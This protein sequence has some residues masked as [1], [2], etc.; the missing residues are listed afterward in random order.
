MPVSDELMVQIKADITQF[1]QQI[2]DVNQQL[3][4][5]ANGA[6]K[7][8]TEFARSFMSAATALRNFRSAMVA[9]GNTAQKLQG[10]GNRKMFSG[11]FDDARNK[12]MAFDA[13][14][15]RVKRDLSSIGS[16]AD[17]AGAKIT[18]AFGAATV[19]ARGFK[20]AMSANHVALSRFKG[21]ASQKL[22]P[23]NEFKDSVKTLLTFHNELKRVG[24]AINKVDG[25]GSKELS[26]GFNS[27]LG[28]ARDLT[29]AVNT[30]SGAFSGI[31][32]A[33][34]ALRDVGESMIDLAGVG[35]KFQDSKKIFEAMGQ[36]LVDFRNATKG[37][38]SDQQ[39][40]KGFGLASSMGLTANEFK[41]FANIAAAAAKKMGVEQ[42]YAF[43][44]IVVGASRSSKKI[45]DNIGIIVDFGYAHEEF[46]KKHG[47][48]VQQLTDEEKKQSELNQVL[49]QGRKIMDDVKAVGADSSEVYDRY[50]ASIENLKTT[51]GSV[52]IPILEH[53]AD[54]A[55]TLRFALEEIFNLDTRSLTT[56]AADKIGTQKSLAQAFK[57]S[58]EAGYITQE[59]A[60]IMMTMGL[61]NDD[62]REMNAAIANNDGA[63]MARLGKKNV[64]G[65][66]QE[67]LKDAVDKKDE[68]KIKSLQEQL[69]LYRALLQVG[70]A[71]DFTQQQNFLAQAEKLMDDAKKT[72]L[73]ETKRQKI[74]G[75]A[76]KGGVDYE[77]DN[78]NAAKTQEK[79]RNQLL[80]DR[81]ELE[82]KISEQLAK[83]A[84]DTAISAAAF[85]GAVE[86]PFQ[87]LLSKLR[88]LDEL[89]AKNQQL[90]GTGAANNLAGISQMTAYAV[91][92]MGN[93]V[94]ETII[95]QENLND[96]MGIAQEFFGKLVSAD[97]S[98]ITDPQALEAIQ[99]SIQ[100]IDAAF[101]AAESKI[102][103]KKVEKRGEI[104]EKIGDEAAR[105]YSALQI[106]AS[107]GSAVEQPFQNLRDSITKAAQFAEDIK[108][109]GAPNSEQSLQ[110]ANKISLLS[111]QMF[112]AEIK[113]A[114]ESTESLTE[115]QK[116]AAE[117]AEKLSSLGDV[118]TEMAAAIGEATDA[119]ND[120]VGKLS[121]QEFGTLVSNGIQ[122][123]ASGGIGQFAGQ[124][125]GEAL[126]T[127]IG[128]AVGVPTAGGA[129]GGTVGNIIGGKLDGI[130]ESLG[131][132]EPLFDGIVAVLETLGPVIQ[133]LQPTIESVVL[134][135]EE[136]IPVLEPILNIA[137]AIVEA[138]GSVI[139][140]IIGI[141]GFVIAPIAFIVE[142]L[143]IL[144][145]GLEFFADAVN[146]VSYW[147]VEGVNWVIDLLN[148]GL[149]NI[150]NTI[151]AILD[152]MHLGRVDLTPIDRLDGHIEIE[153]NTEEL[154]NNTKAVSELT[155]TL[156]GIPQFYKINSAIAASSNYELGAGLSMSTV[157]SVQII[158]DI[159][160]HDPVD[161]NDFTEKLQREARSRLVRQGRR[162]VDNMGTPR[163]TRRP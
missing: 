1:N 124:I 64:M 14:L 54:V 34:L 126:G 150:E 101:A 83:Q 17:K 31:R 114:I 62:K 136:L 82:K 24:T 121:E 99:R 128:G 45:L 122:A 61:N 81:L 30:M 2:K 140:V 74:S 90:G 23:S 152:A 156:S 129:I 79:E 91:E 147:I 149:Q 137:A 153:E 151:N 58:G 131:V 89:G 96:A 78:M 72:A 41:E 26:R 88:E 11:A 29:G 42:E 105:L 15:R 47:K 71:L 94:A 48:T 37:L 55:N 123:F 115:Q 86:K 18:R 33:V 148:V 117:A 107:A 20:N 12:I 95:K 145:Q 21:T 163:A 43:N 32:T 53:A 68:K 40:T 60:N 16:E 119:I 144:A 49:I 161:Y 65:Q 25:K 146:R 10:T 46:A 112:A 87:E 76:R 102:N 13:Q 52:L 111:V 39:L 109:V 35:A 36:D 75:S 100:T 98:E 103:A 135:F 77:N 104:E 50:G 125:G 118:S 162:P 70:K 73:G 133:A 120:H 158:G 8:N 108:E 22:L 44:S 9:S 142:L 67:E 3:T 7:A 80:E 134:L 116:I 84:A 110:N 92:E 93:Q 69:G 143:D 106:A 27:A 85:D 127:V 113:N 160:V 38:L 159:H 6:S 19:S 155:R 5:F 130:I 66:M 139:Q 4:A 132:L 141:L 63:E 59:T 154:A 51:F 57:S 97:I 157:G 28:P 56:K 138:V